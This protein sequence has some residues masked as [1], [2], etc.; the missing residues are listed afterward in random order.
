MWPQ[1]L[2]EHAVSLCSVAAQIPAGSL[3]KE[4][5]DSATSYWLS[6]KLLAEQLCL[7]YF[8]CSD[9]IFCCSLFGLWQLILAVG[10]WEHLLGKSIYLKG[11]FSSV[12]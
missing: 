2:L 6:V 5:F 11:K 10:L 3:V 7:I 8:Q 12:L 4:S 1:C 9:H